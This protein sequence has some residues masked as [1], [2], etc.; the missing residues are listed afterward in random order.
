MIDDTEDGAEDERTIELSAI[1]AIYPELSFDPSNSFSV[2]IDVPIEPQCPLPLHFPNT[3]DGSPLNDLPGAVNTLDLND[4]DNESSS[5]L[6]Q[7][8]GL[9]SQED[10]S[11][12]IHHLSYFPPL[13]LKLSLPVGYP[14]N[15]PPFIEIRCS[16]LPSATVKNIEA[17]GTVLWEEIGKEPVVFAYIDFLREAADDAF[18]L[19]SG[20][21]MTLNVSAALKVSL[22]D[23]DLKERRRKFEKETFECGICLGTHSTQMHA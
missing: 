10:T 22:L 12:E 13:K 20:D 5:K 8:A 16:W 1:Q 3:A 4:G 7:A 19:L 9:R 6:R 23:F 14:E 11:Q 17:K 18:G 21:R 15:R 2:C